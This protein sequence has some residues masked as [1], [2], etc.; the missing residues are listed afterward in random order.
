MP[1][2]GP[3]VQGYLETVVIFLWN[4]PPEVGVAQINDE[5]SHG[6]PIQESCSRSFPREYISK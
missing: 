1:L 2:K 6:T 4:A 3:V 5:I